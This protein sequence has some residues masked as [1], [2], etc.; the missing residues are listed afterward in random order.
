MKRLLKKSTLLFSAIAVAFLMQMPVAAQIQ[1][2]GGVDVNCGATNTVDFFTFKPWNACFT[3]GNVRIE[4]LTD[5]WFI[6]FPVVEDAIK[7]TAY[8]ALGAII[9]GGIKYAKSQGNSNE[10]TAARSTIINAV[11]GLTLA[12]LSVAIVQLITG[13]FTEV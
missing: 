12:V 6:V 7:L 2:G 13:S 9:W 8:I 10:L 5:I 4:K 11:V 3:N 1:P